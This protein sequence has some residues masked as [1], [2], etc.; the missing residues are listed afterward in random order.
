MMRKEILC[1]YGCR[2]EGKG[3]YPRTKQARTEFLKE[4]IQRTN[5]DQ[6]SQQKGP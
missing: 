4:K 2:K 5:V 1:M 3:T 6:S